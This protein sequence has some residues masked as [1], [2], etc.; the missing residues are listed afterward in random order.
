MASI[1]KK[2][3]KG[4]AYYYAAQSQR[5]GGKPRIV[6][7]KYLGTIEAIIGRADEATPK[8]TAAWRA[9]RTS[10]SVTRLPTAQIRTPS[11]PSPSTSPPSR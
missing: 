11:R 9:S 2:V 8:P 7:Q 5:V 4:R 10:R 1:I 6:W 3:K